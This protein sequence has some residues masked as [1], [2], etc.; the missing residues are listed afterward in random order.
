MVLEARLLDQFDDLLA[1]LDGGRHRHRT[2]YVLARL[3][4]RAIDMAP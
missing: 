2:H 4:G 1:L 3:E